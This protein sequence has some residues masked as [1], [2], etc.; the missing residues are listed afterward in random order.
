MTENC[1]C[2]DW[3]VLLGSNYGDFRVTENQARKVKIHCMNN[4]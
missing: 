4:K 1:D 3:G 2:C